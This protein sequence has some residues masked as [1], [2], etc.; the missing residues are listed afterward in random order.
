MSR[1]FIKRYLAYRRRHYRRAVFAGVK[2][3]WVLAVVGRSFV[4]T[5]IPFFIPEST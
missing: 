1:F 2:V 3:R 5:S 4:C